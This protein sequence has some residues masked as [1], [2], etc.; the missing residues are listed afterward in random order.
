MNSRPFMQ[1]D[2]GELE[3]LLVRS[4]SDTEMLYALLKELR[5]RDVPR[6]AVLKEKLLRTLASSKDPNSLNSLIEPD[7]EVLFALAGADMGILRK[8]G[9]ELQQRHERQMRMAAKEEALRANVE[10]VLKPARTFTD[11]KTTTDNHAA[12]ARVFSKPAGWPDARHH[13]LECE[14]C[15]Q[16]LRIPLIQ[17][18]AAYNCHTC[19][20]E[21]T[22][23]H[24][25]GVLTIVFHT[26][27][28]R[29]LFESESALSLDDAYALFNA[30]TTTPWEQIEGERRKLL[31]QYH[32]DKVAS[33]GP[34]LQALAEKEGKRIN[35]AYDFLRRHL[36]SARE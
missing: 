7:L 8:L 16:K 1:S 22:A 9:H 25:R 21:F 30:S 15:G 11:N 13:I 5:H 3:H 4:A 29:N 33:L 20:A 26:D 17:G 36:E 31:H 23:T 14:R 10:A 6:A 19:Q 34:K 32:P 35:M 18:K 28:G 12:K 24:E 27:H 2:I